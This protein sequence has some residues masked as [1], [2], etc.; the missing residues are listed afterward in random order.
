MSRYGR[1]SYTRT[2]YKTA[3]VFAA[4]CAAH[5]ANCGYLK[6]GNTD[7]EGNVI[8]LPNKTL[9]LQFLAGSFDI[10]DEDREFSE[11]VIQFCKSLTFKM[12]SDRKLSAFEKSMLSIVQK[13]TIDSNY[14]IAIISSLPATYI[15][16]T[17]RLITDAR[18]KNAL[19]FVG[20]VGDKIDCN[21]SENWNTYFVTAITPDDKVVFF[22]HRNR[23]EVG[24][25]I[26]GT[27]KV[28]SHRDQ[29]EDSTQLN[30]VKV[31]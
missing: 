5:R 6:I 3:D 17:D 1:S 8:R 10:R 7:D 27:G 9:V 22:A 19:G 31:F 30:Y 26:N 28:K 14:D 4:A 23:L 21:Y 25:N 13:E 15:R 29:Y 12:L 18:I 2:S 11:K 16:A 20:Q 24:A